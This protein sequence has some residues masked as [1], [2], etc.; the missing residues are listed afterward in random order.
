MIV[1]ILK[2]DERFNIKKGQLFEAKRY[3]LDPQEK[4]TLLKRVTKKDFSPIGEEV[5]CNQY[6]T[7]V[8]IITKNYEKNNH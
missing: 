7:D 5:L 1:E 6:F 8:N 2:N 4:V 3:W